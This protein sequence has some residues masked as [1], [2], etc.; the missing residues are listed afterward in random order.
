VENKVGIIEFPVRGGD[1]EHLGDATLKT[2]SIIDKLLSEIECYKLFNKKKEITRKFGI[3]SY[4]AEANIAIH[5]FFGILKTIIY[6]NKI[7]CSAMD[8]GP[9]IPSLLLALTPGFSTASEKARGLGFGAGMG[10]K[11]IQKISD[12]FIITSRWG[13]GTYLLFEIWRDDL[14]DKDNRSIEMKIR[15]IIELLKLEVL[16]KKIEVNLEREI[17]TAYSCDL[18]SYVLSKGK[19]ESAWLTVQTNI[20]IVGVAS[21]KRIPIIIITEDSFVPKETIEKAEE[22]HVIIARASQDTFEVSGKLYELLR[23]N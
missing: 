21:I 17:E 4:E 20:N 23:G 7:K 13:K 14:S 15:E 10:L 8:V 16:T 19:E 11:N 5:S 6:C 18:L 3:C 2:R 12:L 22:S 9:G 1:F